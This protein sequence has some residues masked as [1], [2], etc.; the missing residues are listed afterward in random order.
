VPSLR[1]ATVLADSRSGLTAQ[2]EA[3]IGAAH[4][5]GKSFAERRRHELQ[6]VHGQLQQPVPRIASESR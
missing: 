3:V 1:H 6:P 4:L 2:W 5:A